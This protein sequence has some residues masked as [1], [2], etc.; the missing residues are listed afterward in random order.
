MLATDIKKLIFEAIR[1][2]LGI[3]L[4]VSANPDV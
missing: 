4:I 2:I 1:F 3:F